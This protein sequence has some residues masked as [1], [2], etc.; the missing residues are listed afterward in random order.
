MVRG[1][2]QNTAPFFVA[3]LVLWFVSVIFE[4]VFNK[5]KE[6]V[7]IIAGCCFYQ[8]ANWVIRYSLSKDP[9]LVNTSV[10]LLHSTITS[11]SV[12]LILVNQ[13]ANISFSEMLEHAQLFGGTWAG[14]YSALC[15]SCG[16]FAYD[17]WDM[18][19]YR[20]YS[21]WIPSILVHHLILLVCFTLALY[22]NVTVN[23][24][25]LTLVCELHSVFLHVR[26]VRRMAGVLDSKSKIVRAEWIIN[27]VTFFVARLA[28][29][30]FITYK[31]IRDAP[32]FGRGV[33]LPLALSGMAGMNLLNLFLGVDLFK[34]YRQEKNQYKQHKRQE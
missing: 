25:I 30:I 31:L 29:H 12:V 6:L 13:W 34:A 21:G 7:A 16:Y 11:F 9:L 32:K 14:S 26:K 24:L 1:S 8:V 15:F 3:T 5:R 20:L 4:I 2:S 27:W 33:E 23:Y 22:R 10:S 17:Q 28:C 18:L 19:L